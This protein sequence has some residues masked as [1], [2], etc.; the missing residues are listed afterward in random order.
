MK[1]EHP[2][3]IATVSR[4]DTE[5]DARAVAR[6]FDMESIRHLSDEAVACTAKYEDAKQAF[7][8]RQ[9]DVVNVMKF[10]SEEWQRLSVRCL[11]PLLV[12]HSA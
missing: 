1:E 5:F 7:R 6:G 12:A 11:D 8:R 2:Q 10:Q 4:V 9:D 3:A